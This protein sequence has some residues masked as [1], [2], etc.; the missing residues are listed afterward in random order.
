MTRTRVARCGCGQLSATCLGEPVRV[1]VCHC[2]WCQRRTGGPFAAQARF[3]ADAVTIVGES[4][5]W[6][7]V[8][9]GGR[10][11]WF[12]RCVECGSLVAYVNE[13]M[14]DTVAIPLGGFDPDEQPTPTIS[15]FEGRKRPWVEIVGAEIERD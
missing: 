4:R 7:R 14:E 6:E 10:R 1:S 15:V 9:E 8:G 2:H 5:V 12:R 3:P 13:G 11:A